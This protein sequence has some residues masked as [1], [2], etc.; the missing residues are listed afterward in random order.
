M[1]VPNI[2]CVAPVINLWSFKSSTRTVIP[3]RTPHELT[4]VN[5]EYIHFLDLT[6]TAS[7]ISIDLL[8]PKHGTIHRARGEV[9]TAFLSSSFEE[10]GLFV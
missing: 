6:S 10:E 9:W 8:K 4:E 1:E 3:F 5:R 7:L 2:S